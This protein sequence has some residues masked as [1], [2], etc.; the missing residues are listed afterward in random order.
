MRFVRT[1]FGGGSLQSRVLALALRQSAKRVVTAWSW[2]PFLP[3]PY[4]VVDQVGRLQAQVRG[5]RI[6]QVRLADCRAERISTPAARPDRHVV[7]FH[8]GAFL[9]GGRHLHHGLISRIAHAT[10]ATVLAVEY[11]KLPKHAVHVSVQDSLAAYRRVLSDGVRPEEILFMGDSAGGYLAFL[12]AE[13]ARAEGLPLPA[14]IVAISPL[15]DFDL[16]RSPVGATCDLFTTRAIKQFARLARRVAREAGLRSAPDCELG[17]LPPVL[18]QVSS[19]ELL[20]PQALEHAKR[21]FAAGVPVELQVWDGQVHV[22]QAAALLPEAQ[23]AVANIGR[24]VDQVLTAE[25]RAE[26][27]IA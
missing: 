9:V 12:V 25:V 10:Q 20:F 17:G 8:G 4:F 26:T 6:S 19:S 21:L 1:D 2:T 22:F 24:F 13:A 15:I 27:P 7:Y 14:A 5:T 3:W 11:R 23:Q 16:T 18:I